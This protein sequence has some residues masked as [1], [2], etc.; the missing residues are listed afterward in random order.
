M[1]LQHAH[2]MIVRDSPCVADVTRANWLCCGIGFSACS[3]VAKGEG[4]HLYYT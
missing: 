3:A 1:L 2:L 4:F